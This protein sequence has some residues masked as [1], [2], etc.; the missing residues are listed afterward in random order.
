MSL[1]P[2]AIV[3]SL[4]LRYDEAVFYRALAESWIPLLA[5]PMQF[6]SG[7]PPL[8]PPWHPLA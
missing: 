4:D 2:W 8:V 5:Q 7:E 1:G 6:A 3:P